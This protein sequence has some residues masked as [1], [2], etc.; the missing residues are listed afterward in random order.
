MTVNLKTLFGVGDESKFRRNFLRVAWANVIALAL[1][2][3]AAPLLSRL[4]LPSDFGAQAVFTSILSTLLAFCSW[5][6][7]WVMPNA[8]TRVMAAT[9]FVTGAGVLVSVCLIV[10]MVVLVL[11]A[12]P[13]P[14]ARTAG[15][16]LLLI[17]LPVALFAGGLRDLLGAWFVRQGDLTAKSRA[18]IFESLTNVLA[19]VSAG[20]AAMGSG[21]LIIS[22]TLATWAG[23]SSLVHHSR[24]LLWAS[25]QRISRKRLVAGI[26][27][28]SRTASWSSLSAVVSALS[29]FAPI[30]L[31]TYFYSQKE[32]GWYALMYRL[33]GAPMGVLTSAL[34]QSF[35]AKAAEY[36]RADRIEEL[37]RLYRKITLRL[38]YACLPVVA[39]CLSGPLFVGPI[40]GR[41]EWDG[42][43]YVLMAMLPLFVGGTVF[44]PTSHLI[45]LDRQHWKLV[46]D[47]ARLV[48]VAVSI[49]LARYWGIG[50]VA[51]VW[52]ASCASLI[53]H[54]LLYLMHLR[55]HKSA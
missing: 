15:L 16:G 3:L 27:R 45:V 38:M 2:I 22:N 1:P 35:W 29:Q 5:R 21:G 47:T 18:T 13:V 23:I 46:A 32:V 11:F 48:L 43:G 39:I 14:E 55:A 30:F 51:A 8:R 31:L 19:S 42:A 34:G 50:F 36:A 41:T 25:I 52:L 7:D 4:F 53:G 10:M 26:V 24:K 17:L 12:L 49:G 20:V 33:L 37:G 28:N 9:L 54:A 40:L 44:S 6:F